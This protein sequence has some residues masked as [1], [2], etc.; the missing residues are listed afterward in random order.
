[1]IFH[2][3]YRKHQ[4]EIMPKALKGLIENKSVLKVSRFTCEMRTA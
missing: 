2:L 4:P 1:M 3:T